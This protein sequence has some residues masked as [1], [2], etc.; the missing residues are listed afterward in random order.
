RAQ[1]ADAESMLE[2]AH[3]LVER[4]GQ[5]DHRMLADVVDAHERRRQQPGHRSGAHDMAGTVLGEHPGHEGAYAVDDAPDVDPEQPFPVLQA[6][7]PKESS[8]RDSGVVE[9]QVDLAMA[10]EGKPCE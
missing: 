8:G 10:V 5:G 9:E 2:S 1:D 6:M 4:F 3:V 7:F